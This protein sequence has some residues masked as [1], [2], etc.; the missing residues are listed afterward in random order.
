MS[1][2]NMEIVRRVFEEF[3]RAGLERG[4]PGAFFD[5]ETAAD[6][7][8]WIVRNLGSSREGRWRPP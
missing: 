1:Q 2:E 5:S 6:D 7:Y 8:K 3:Q 4:D